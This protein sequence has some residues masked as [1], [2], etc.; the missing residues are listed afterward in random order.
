M[1]DFAFAFTLQTH[2]KVIL[3]GAGAQ[4]VVVD[5]AWQGQVALQR[6]R[7]HL[8]LQ[9]QLRLPRPPLPLPN[10]N[11]VLHKVWE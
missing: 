10:I 5:G 2:Y 6:L 1:R 3:G 8:A 7:R 4:N 11:C 9:L